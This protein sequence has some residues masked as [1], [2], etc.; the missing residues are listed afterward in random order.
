MEREVEAAERAAARLGAGLRVDA[1]RLDAGMAEQVGQAHDVLLLPVEREGKEMA[2]VVREHLLRG[3]ARRRAQPF[4]HAP[5]VRAVERVAV[6]RDE[7]GPGGDALL[8]ALLLHLHCKSARK[9]VEAR[10]G[11]SDK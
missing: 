5:D 7:H 11:L 1:G 8:P 2:Q 6:L 4:H 10:R 9:K 3:H